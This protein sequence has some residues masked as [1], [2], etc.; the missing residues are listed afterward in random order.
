M[1]TLNSS[2]TEVNAVIAP[3]DPKYFVNVEGTE[4]SW[5]KDTITT[6]EIAALGGWGN[7]GVV[8]IDADNVEHTLVPGQVIHIVP[9]HGFAKKIKWQRGDG[10]FENRISS[11]LH[12]LQGHFQDVKQQ[13][14]WF[15]IPEYPFPEG[16][17]LRKANIAFRVLPGYPATPPYGFFVPT[18]LRFNGALPSNYQDGVADVPPFAGQWGMFSWAPVEWKSSDSVVAGH[19]L[20]N[21][22]LSFAVRFQQGG[23]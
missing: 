11:E 17:S 14:N 3:I 23:A 19:N 10:V 16:W 18:G 20:L 22:A 5:P 7:E 4:H 21:F 12:H 13:D 1:E 2:K 15:L 6:E 9:G 8:Q